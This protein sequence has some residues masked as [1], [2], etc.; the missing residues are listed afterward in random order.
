MKK[1]KKKKTN[2]ILSFYK[3]QVTLKAPVSSRLKK[4]S[5]DEPVLYLNGYLLE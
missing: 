3:S 4:L 5:S 1:R 2:K